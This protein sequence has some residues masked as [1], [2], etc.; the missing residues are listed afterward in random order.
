VQAI[1]PLK[2]KMATWQLCKSIFGFWADSDTYEANGT[3]HVKF[4]TADHNI[5][6]E[7][8]GCKTVGNIFWTGKIKTMEICQAFML[9]FIN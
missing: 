8:P 9:H 1:F 3:R 2:R 6:T 5:P 4:D 7:K